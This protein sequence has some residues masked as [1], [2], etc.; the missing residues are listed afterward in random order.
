MEKYPIMLFFL[1][2]AHRAY[3]QF[4]SY[5]FQEELPKVKSKYEK[6]LPPQIEVRESLQLANDIP[7]PDFD[8]PL[9]LAS[10]PLEEF[11]LTS[12]YGFRSDPFSGKNTFHR[13]IDLKADRSTVLSL[14]HGKVSLTGYDSV[15]GNFVKVRHGKYEAV[16]GHL[17]QVL[18]AV[19]EEVLPRTLIGISGSTGKATG[20]HLHLSIKNGK[21]FVNPILFLQMITKLRTR[22]EFFTY[23]S[24]P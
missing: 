6:A 17:S 3:P 23:L 7:L 12:Q 9:S 2:A 14:L 20:D 10:L 5:V 13:G 11:E 19:G 18:V 15:L 1:F 21:E 8:E 24:K 4:H 16:Y 22:E